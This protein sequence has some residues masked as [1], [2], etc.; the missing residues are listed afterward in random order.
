LAEYWEKNPGLITNKDGRCSDI[1]A[2][3][4][5]SRKMSRLE[6][7]AESILRKAINKLSAQNERRIASSEL[8][9]YIAEK[10]TGYNIEIRPGLIILYNEKE[11]P[12]SIC[13][14]TGLEIIP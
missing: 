14:T 9:A 4:A 2:K 12:I 3:I 1:S 13:D 6:E 10:L 7:I 11:E 5:K 8:H